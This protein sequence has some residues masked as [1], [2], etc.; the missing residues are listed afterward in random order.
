MLVAEFELALC[1]SF[2]TCRIQRA[3]PPGTA[4]KKP[5]FTK[6][7]AGD[8]R[9]Q[10]DVNDHEKAGALGAADQIQLRGVR[11]VL[12]MPQRPRIYYSESQKALM[13]ERWRKG[14]SLQK[15]A[16][17]FDQNHS[18]IQQIFAVTGGIEPPRRRR[19]NHALTLAEREEISRGLVAGQT[20]RSIA[21]TLGR[22]RAKCHSALALGGGRSQQLKE[23]F[24]RTFNLRGD[25]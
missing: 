22:A 11:G 10:D 8:E 21:D 19:S 18:S 2:R 7:L 12:Q 17:L 14:E 20:I 16:Q 3:T 4:P 13:W 24:S 15:I 6:P 25:Y 1:G 23:C 9:H 5:L